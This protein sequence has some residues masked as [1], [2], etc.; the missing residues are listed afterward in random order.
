[1]IAIISNIFILWRC[2]GS[3]NQLTCHFR[4]VHQPRHA[5]VGSSLHQ[6]IGHSAQIVGVLGKEKAIPE[7]VDEPRTAHIP[8][9]P[10]WA[11]VL[12][13]YRIR[14]CPEVGIM[15]GT[16]ARINTIIIAGG[17]LAIG[18]KSLDKG[19]QRL[20]HLGKITHKHRPVVLLQIDVHSI[21]ASP[22]RPQLVRPQSLKIGRYPRRTTT[23]DEQITS[24][25]E[26]ERL[27]IAF[28]GRMLSRLVGILLK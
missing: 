27:Q 25:L 18:G 15:A 21:V 6:R 4:I 13:S 24:K 20:S 9:S 16:P 7:R 2:T 14:H 11:F 22:R 10:L 5:K 1:M 19:I 28:S 3:R 26:V 17:I 12:L 8:V 23:R